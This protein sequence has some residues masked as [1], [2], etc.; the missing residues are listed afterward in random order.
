MDRLV[1]VEIEPEEQ[2]N[3]FLPLGQVQQEIHAWTFG[4]AAEQDRDLL[5]FGLTSQGIAGDGLNLESH[6]RGS[7]RRT[8]I[9]VLLEQP[10]QLGAT[11]L[12]PRPGIAYRLAVS[13]P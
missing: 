13:Q 2:G 9:H 6:P 3:L 12:P 8:S 5:A 7:A 10:Q 1:S 4:I 11:T